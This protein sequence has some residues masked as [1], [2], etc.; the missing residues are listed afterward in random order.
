MLKYILFL[1]SEHYYE[2]VKER[3]GE[4][5]ARTDAHQPEIAVRRASAGLPAREESKGGRAPA[6][7]PERKESREKKAPAGFPVREGMRQG[8]T[9]VIAD[10]PE[11][12]R[13]LLDEGWFVVVLYHEHNRELSFPQ[14]RYGVEDVFGLE[15]RSY[16]EAYRRLAGLPWDILE[17]DR[18]EVRESTLEDVDEFY[19]IYE[20]PSVTFYM[21]NLYERREEETAYMKAYID[22]VYGFYGYGLWSVLLKGTGQVIGRAGLSVREG[23][24]LPELGFV[25]GAAYQ[26]RGY[27]FEVCAAV[28]AYARLELGFERV[29][30]L[31]KEKNLASRRLLTKLGF[32]FE[33]NVAESGGSYMLYIK[34]L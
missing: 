27:G 18:L 13:K 12:V 26:R 15:Y 19:R 11:T 4:I 29:Q 3:L 33:R 10:E 17:T 23:Y 32:V 20:D 16:E 24:E 21:E 31:V 9:L 8:E 14:V 28:L 7:L 25:I 1:L 22:Q 5:R 6:S 34:T 2:T 30:A